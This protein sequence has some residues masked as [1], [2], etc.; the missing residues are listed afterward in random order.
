MPAKP[1]D[2]GRK[3][4]DGEPD[5]T[6]F[7]RRAPALH[8]TARRTPVWTGCSA[9]TGLRPARAEQY[10][11]PIKRFQ[12]V[13][14]SHNGDATF[15]DYA[16]AEGV[17]KNVAAYRGQLTKAKARAAAVTAR[18]AKPGE[19]ARPGQNVAVGKSSP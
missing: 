9:D 12:K 15:L 17:V 10:W 8:L 2:E 13:N 7:V 14:G 18:K 3:A 16:D 11:C 4:A 5:P 1:T 19:T 6:S